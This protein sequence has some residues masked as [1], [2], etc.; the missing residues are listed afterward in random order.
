MDKQLKCMHRQRGNLKRKLTILYNFIVPIENAIINSADVSVDALSEFK[1]RFTN[2][3][4][5]LSEYDKIQ[6]EIE[7]L[8]TDDEIENEQIERNQFEN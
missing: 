5:L 8:C 7:L 2:H 4:L 1:L 3:K 6:L